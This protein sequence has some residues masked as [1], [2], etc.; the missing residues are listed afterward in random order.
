MEQR[1][2][3]ILSDG[4]E[5]GPGAEIPDRSRSNYL[6]P[7]RWPDLLGVM[8]HDWSRCTTTEGMRE[9][10]DDRAQQGAIYSHP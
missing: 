7:D 9:I 3:G 8:H 1:I 4:L 10:T 2:I 6:C 5:G